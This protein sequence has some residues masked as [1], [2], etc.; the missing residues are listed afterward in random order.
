MG[1]VVVAPELWSTG[2]MF[3]AHRL[4]CS[5]A[6]KMWDLPGPDTQPMSSA[7]ADG[8]F[9]TEPLGKPHI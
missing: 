7:L 1:S 8:F 5:M 6:I 2:S 4:N 9:I 3:V